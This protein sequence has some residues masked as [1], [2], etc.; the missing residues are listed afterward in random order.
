MMGPVK[1][2]FLNK[3]REICR[4]HT[5]TFEE[6]IPHI[7]P[8]MAVTNDCSIDL[9][10]KM[11]LAYLPTRTI[12][13][14]HVAVTDGVPCRLGDIDPWLTPVSLFIPQMWCKCTNYMNILNNI[15]EV[16]HFNEKQNLT[17]MTQID[18][19]PRKRYRVS[20]LC[21]CMCYINI[22][23]KIEE[24][25]HFKWKSKFDYYERND[26]RLTFDPIT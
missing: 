3:T 18:F 14:R 9:F 13:T 4:T 20:S 15:K 1:M 10:Y 2:E 24:L 6:R 5:H 26:P 12:T 8:S 16:M 11:S 23:W 22:L 17:P 21:I 25:M 7:Y 19:W